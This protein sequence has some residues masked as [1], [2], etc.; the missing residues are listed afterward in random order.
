MGSKEIIKYV[1]QKNRL[2]GV[3]FACMNGNDDVQV[4][5]SMAHKNDIPPAQSIEGLKLGGFNKKFG[6]KLARE[7]AHRFGD[8]KSIRLFKGKVNIINRNGKTLDKNMYIIGSTVESLVRSNSF[9]KAKGKGNNIYLNELPKGNSFVSIPVTLEKPF[10][11]FIKNCR[12]Y[13]KNKKFPYWVELFL[14]YMKS[15]TSK[16]IWE[17]KVI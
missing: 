11:V 13:Y 14:D 6:I 17:K 5:F 8:F 7:R 15:T 9:R 16:V 10:Y 12:R 3:L 2:K 1:R 4:G